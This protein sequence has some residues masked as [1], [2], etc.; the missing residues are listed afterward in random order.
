[1]KTKTHF[2]SAFLAAAA[3][4]NPAEIAQNKAKRFNFHQKLAKAR[5]P[6]FSKIEAEK[7]VAPVVASDVALVVASVVAS[8]NPHS[9]IRIP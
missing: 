9:V 1:M 3:R 8:V 2:W 5:V 7:A 4:S 6:F